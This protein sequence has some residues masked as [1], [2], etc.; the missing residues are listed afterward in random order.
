MISGGTGP[1]FPIPSDF[2]QVMLFEFL[3]LDFQSGSV[4]QSSLTGCWEGGGS[5]EQIHSIA[6]SPEEALTKKVKT[7][8]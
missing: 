2:G 3:N 8:T 4:H 6:P 5:A 7:I 1:C